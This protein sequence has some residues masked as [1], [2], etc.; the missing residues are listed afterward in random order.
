MAKKLE[1]MD[2]EEFMEAWT[3][4]AQ[5]LDEARAKVR[6]FA[7]ERQRRDA[8]ARLDTMSDEEKRQLAQYVFPQGIESQEA[9][10]NG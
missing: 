6:E 7:D 3:D 10:N 2:D 1:N 5:K 4:A 8:L 9:V